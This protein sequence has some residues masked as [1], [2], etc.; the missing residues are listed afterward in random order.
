MA[1]MIYDGSRTELTQGTDEGTSR[2]SQGPRDL[3]APPS[4]GPELDIDI[5]VG[6][7][8]PRPG[9]AKKASPWNTTCRMPL[10]ESCELRFRRGLSHEFGR[11]TEG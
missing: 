7:S 8:R 10:D 3:A 2:F 4:M 11:R 5:S 9:R 6:M 1:P